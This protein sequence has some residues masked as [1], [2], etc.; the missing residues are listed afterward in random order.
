MVAEES[1]WSDHA[2]QQAAGV[3]ERHPLAGFDDIDRQLLALLQENDRRSLAELSAE[4]GAAQS[5]LNDRI[6]RLVSQGVLAGFHA[7]VE[8]EAVGLNL[9]AFIFVG[10]SD[11]KVEPV[12]LRK[13]KASSD[14]LEC[15]HVTGAWNY[16]MKVRVGTT[17]D[18]E[19]FL[20]ETVK[21][22]SGVQRTETVIVLSSA[23]ETWALEPPK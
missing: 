23:K 10:W 11:P 21:T 13:I 22:V 12:F 7:R 15:H 3:R 18:L 9:L 4:I 6:K 19:R 17:R 20:A 1:E 8:P 16:L 5:T 2:G 14:V